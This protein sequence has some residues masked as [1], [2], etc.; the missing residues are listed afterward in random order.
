MILKLYSHSK[1]QV[2]NTVLLTV[3]TMRTLDPQNSC[4]NRKFVPFD[5]CLISPTT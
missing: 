2:H 4:Y 3:V 5:Q 1:F